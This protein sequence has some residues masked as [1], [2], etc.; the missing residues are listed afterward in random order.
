MLD[1]EEIGDLEWNQLLENKRHKELVVIFKQVIVAIKEGKE[2]SKEN[3]ISNALL[4]HSETIDFFVK[5]IEEVSKPQVTIQTDDKN[6]IKVLDALN[7]LRSEAAK[8]TSNQEEIVSLLSHKAKKLK[9]NRSPNG[10][11][12]EDI[13]IEYDKINI[14]DGR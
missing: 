12:I 3:E 14:K 8:I 11:F 9:V 13:D 5:K 1:D 10:H 2:G 4:K 6:L 7:V